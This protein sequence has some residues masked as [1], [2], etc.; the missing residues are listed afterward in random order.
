MSIVSLNLCSLFL[1][2]LW[3]SIFALLFCPNFCL[4]VQMGSTNERHKFFIFMK[5]PR[6]PCH[7]AGNAE[8]SILSSSDRSWSA[9]GGYIWN[10]S[11][12]IVI[13]SPKY[14]HVC[15]NSV[16]KFIH[17]FFIL[18]FISVVWSSSTTSLFLYHLIISL[19][20]FVLHENN[21]FIFLQ[22]PIFYFTRRSF[23][24]FI[25]RLLVWNQSYHFSGFVWPNNS[26]DTQRFKWEAHTR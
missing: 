16:Q 11:T 25:I 8:N 15:F 10:S 3:F 9:A 19:W 4:S 13:Y 18:Y 23:C 5:I 21:I 24:H 17:Y 6:H 12:H 14:F 22:D 2:K 7:P 1:E 26:K 20:L